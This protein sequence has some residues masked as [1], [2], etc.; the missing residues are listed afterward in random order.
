MFFNKYNFLLKDFTSRNDIKPEISGI[1]ITSQKTVATD[2]FMLVMVDSVKASKDD[3]PIIPNKPTPRSDFKPFILPTNKAKDILKFFG[4]QNSD[5]P[6]LDNAVVMARDKERVEI[7]KTDLESYNSVTSNIIEGRFP[8]YN[9]L[10]VEK[11][12]YIEV[13]LDPAF[14]KKIAT[15]FKDFIGS[16]NPIKIRIPLNQEFGAVKFSGERKETG[17]KAQALL[18]PKQQ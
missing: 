9:Q 2:G 12:K 3:Y 6:I 11:G 1:F 15:F 16:G 7:G 17:Q 14:L 13:H 10:F 18:M 5:L 4:S 8:D